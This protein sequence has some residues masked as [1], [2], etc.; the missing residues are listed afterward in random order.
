MTNTKSPSQRYPQRIFSHWKSICSGF[1]LLKVTTILTD[2][3]NTTT[4]KGT[5]KHWEFSQSRKISKT[6]QNI[7][8]EPFAKQHLFDNTS[9]TKNTKAYSIVKVKC[10]PWAPALT[11][12]LD[13][14]PQSV[15]YPCSQLPSLSR[16]QPH[17]G[18]QQVC[19][20]LKSTWE[21]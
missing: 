13:R 2:Q 15:T 8:I 4:K 16:Q 1:R 5:K 14:F 7:Q 12:H 20:Q 9:V 6:I 3:D 17:G 11:L 10:A 18:K 21:I 19:F